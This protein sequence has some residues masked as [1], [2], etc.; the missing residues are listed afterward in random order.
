MTKYTN[1]INLVGR[2]RSVTVWLWTWMSIDETWRKNMHI[3]FPRN[4]T[5]CCSTQSI[6]VGL[7][8]IVIN[9]LTLRLFRDRTWSWFMQKPA[10]GKC[11]VD[12][13]H[14]QTNNHPA[15]QLAVT[16]M[17]S[18]F[19]R[20]SIKCFS[21][22]SSLS[23]RRAIHSTSVGSSF[24]SIYLR[25][26]Y[27][28]WTLKILVHK[29]VQN[30]DIENL[31]EDDVAFEPDLFTEPKPDKTITQHDATTKTKDSSAST[32]GSSSTPKRRV[33]ALSHSLKRSALLDKHIH[34]MKPRLGS[35]PSKK[36]PR[37]RSR[38]W[39]TMLQL[40][41]NGEDMTKVVEL[42]PMLRDGGGALP[43]LFAEVFVR[44]WYF[45]ETIL[46]P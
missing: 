19:L 27:F 26:N 25:R 28:N 15:C 45:L 41:K 4:K 9:L 30:F 8:Y 22:C 23:G 16:T 29:K 37:I 33:S 14:N 46:N 10:A 18:F 20:H 31:F 24:S 44:E 6:V 13:K 32:E 35:S 21:S 3:H 12:T 34:F 36:H 2:S 40:A 39:L 43:S 38:T 11:R 7:N 1:S 42:I 17:T 5:P